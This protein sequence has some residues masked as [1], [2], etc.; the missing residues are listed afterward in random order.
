MDKEMSYFKS[1]A[2]AIL[3]G[4]FCGCDSDEAKPTVKHTNL[5]D[6]GDVE[7]ETV[8]IEGCQYLYFSSLHEVVLIHKGNC[9]NPM[10]LYRLEKQDGQ[11][12]MRVA[13]KDASARNGLRVPANGS[14]TQLVICGKTT[15]VLFISKDQRKNKVKVWVK[16][17]TDED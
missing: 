17:D 1:I 11:E 5:T 9:D 14:L 8:R 6:I 2:L 10:H 7:Y 12:P 15:N 3:V 4:L 16:R 13:N